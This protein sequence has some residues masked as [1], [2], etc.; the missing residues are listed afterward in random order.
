MKTWI[1][2]PEWQCVKNVRKDLCREYERKEK[3]S[4]VAQSSRTLWDPM[5]CSLPES[6]IHGIFQARILE[7]IWDCYQTNQIHVPAHS[8]AHLLTLG[9]VEGKCR[10]RW[11]KCTKE[12]RRA[13]AEKNLNSQMDFRKTFLQV[14]WRREVAGCVISSWHKPLIGWWWGIRA[15]SQGLILSML[16]FQDAWGYVPLVIK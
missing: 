11:W 12:S 15:V 2:G 4:E 14:R 5:D 1:I 6:S 8:K 3:E 10:L 9:C 7:C 13:N 16:R